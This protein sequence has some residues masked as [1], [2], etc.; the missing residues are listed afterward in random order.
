MSCLPEGRRAGLLLAMFSRCRLLL[1]AL[2]ASWLAT[3][4]VGAQEQRWS[5]PAA[6]ALS[7]SY[8]RIAEREE[9]LRSELAKLPQLPVSQQS[10]R[11]G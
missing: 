6:R 9:T 2:G 11:I 8:R 3:A 10:E 1:Y 7:A 4:G 5:E